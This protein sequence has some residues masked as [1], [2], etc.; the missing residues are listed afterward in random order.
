MVGASYSM[1]PRSALTL[2]AVV[3]CTVSERD[4]L[5]LRF[6]SPSRSHVSM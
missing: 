3:A 1:C 2:E 5:I 4:D 6:V